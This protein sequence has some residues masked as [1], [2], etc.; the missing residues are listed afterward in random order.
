MIYEVTSLEIPKEIGGVPGMEM[1]SDVEEFED[2][3][4]LDISPEKVLEAM[5]YS[6]PKSVTLE[7]LAPVKNVI[8]F[9]QTLICFDIAELET[10]NSIVI[11]YLMHYDFVH[12]LQWYFSYVLFLNKL[13]MF[14]LIVF[15]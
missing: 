7:P 4:M 12:K 2:R 5:L 1:Q 14:Q 6:D 3:S 13:K 8:H 9:V 10:R 11:E 15:K